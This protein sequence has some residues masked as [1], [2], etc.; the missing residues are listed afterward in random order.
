MSGRAF[1]DPLPCERKSLTAY[2]P[3]LSAHIT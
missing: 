3:V 1:F 2:Q